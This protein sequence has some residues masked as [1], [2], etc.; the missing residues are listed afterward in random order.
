MADPR[1]SQRQR[2]APPIDRWHARRGES[3]GGYVHANP[4][5]LAP[6][7]ENDQARFP[8]TEYDTAVLRDKSPFYH[9]ETRANVGD[10]WVNWT[11]AGPPRAEL[12]MRTSTYRVEQGGTRYPFIPTSPTGGR[13]TMVPS[14]T[15][16]TTPRYVDAGLPQMTAARINRLS[17]ARYSGQSYSQTTAVQGRSIRR[18]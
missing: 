11:A 7:M 2:A 1:L 6:G 3:G 15:T 9:A 4:L 18:G 17:A 14:A 12:H 13:H 8:G 10:G 16:Y 5:T